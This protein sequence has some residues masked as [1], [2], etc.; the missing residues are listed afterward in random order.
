MSRLPT[1][2]TDRRKADDEVSALTTNTG[3]FSTNKK[4]K[5]EARDSF[6]E[7]TFLDVNQYLPESYRLGERIDESEADIQHLLEFSET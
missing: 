4:Q 6:A 3:M 5:Q 2:G 7:L 1:V